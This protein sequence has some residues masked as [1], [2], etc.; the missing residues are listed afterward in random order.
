MKT[1]LVA[2]PLLVATA[3]NADLFDCGNSAQR[4]VS[5]SVSGVSRVVVIGRAGSLRVSG[6]PAARQVVA[7]GTA[8]ASDASALASIQLESRVSGSDLIIEAVIPERMGLFSWGEAKLDF[9]VALPDNIAL[10]VRDGSGDL[11][12][13]NAG[14]LHVLDGSGELTIR[15]V[16]GNV[17]VTDGS[18]ELTIS[19]VTGDVKVTDGSGEI[20]INRVGGSVLIVE[21]GSG[22]IDIRNVQRNVTIGVDGSGSISVSDVRG[23]FV[24][25]HDGSGGVSYDRVSGKVSVPRE[26]D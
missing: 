14:P 26:R 19:D 2:L 18:G 7:T 20:D 4:R 15:G 10:D 25:E 16:H 13:E 17:E 11:I 9:E 21:D 1:L 24:V 23:D 8:C 12:I 6:R 22:G 5:A 3:A